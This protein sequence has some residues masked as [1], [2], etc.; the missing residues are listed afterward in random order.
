M[1]AALCVALG[2]ALLMPGA[3]A[4]PGGSA[5]GEIPPTCPEGTYDSTYLGGDDFDPNT[6]R[7]MDWTMDPAE[8]GWRI[9]GPGEGGEW[10]L[11]ADPVPG[12]VRATSGWVQLPNVR[13]IQLALRHSP[14]PWS[15]TDQYGALRV[16]AANGEELAEHGF[17]ADGESTT[18][19]VNLTA[20][21]GKTVQVQLDLN[22]R[23]DLSP[24][25][26]TGWDIDDISLHTCFDPIPSQPSLRNAETYVKNASEAV[27]AWDNPSWTGTGLTGYKVTVT[28]PGSSDQPQVHALPVDQRVLHLAG[29]TAGT[30]LVEV[31]ANS[32]QGPSYPAST[33]FHGTVPTASVRGG[34]R[35]VAY[36]E[37]STLDIN[38]TREDGTTF[39]GGFMR[40]YGRTKGAQSYRAIASFAHDDI[41]GDE[42]DQV[43]AVNTEYQIEF[44]PS[45]EKDSELGSIRPGPSISVRPAVTAAFNATSVAP[46]KTVHLR[47][48]VRPWHPGTAVK[49]QRYV[50]GTWRTAQTK[51]L[52]STSG[53]DFSIKNWTKRKYTYRVV[54]AAHTD[55]ATGYSPQRSYYVR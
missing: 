50:D 20:W 30:Y 45:H 28:R 5:A 26:A 41:D 17:H 54:I 22:T 37:T 49:L 10:R 53:Y 38:V 48:Q 6:E 2:A 4:A 52:S 35:I 11:H 55:H 12:T 32:A 9:E 31:T 29:L 14:A 39:V 19:V 15:A 23:R 36:G 16:L 27:V 42:F 43:V 18:R 7:A 1:L 24:G 33:T 47:G 34:K 25:T 46:G 13:R 8:G 44:D 3:S 51:A 21:R 40:L